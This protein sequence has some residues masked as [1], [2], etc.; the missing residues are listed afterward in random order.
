MRKYNESGEIIRNI[1]VKRPK[2]GNTRQYRG[3]V[4]QNVMK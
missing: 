2:G 1:A 3:T 4:A